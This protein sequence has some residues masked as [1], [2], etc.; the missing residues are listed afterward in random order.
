MA[1]LKFCQ[2]D[3]LSSFL[4]LFLGLVH[5]SSRLATCL[6][7]NRVI[8]YLVL[9][10]SVLIFSKILIQKAMAKPE[11]EMSSNFLA[12]CTV[13]NKNKKET[14]NFHSHHNQISTK[15]RP[16]GIGLNSNKKWTLVTSYVTKCEMWLTFDNIVP[17]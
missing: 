9:I 15:I 11:F 4:G 3:L 2:Y 13:V 16:K 10:F 8:Y 14:A 5:P 1:S 12:N 17:L 7:G 6:S